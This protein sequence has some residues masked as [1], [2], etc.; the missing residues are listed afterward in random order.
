MKI[1]KLIALF[2][3]VAGVNAYAIDIWVSPSGNDANKGTKDSPLASIMMAQR[4]AREMRRLRK[5]GVENGINI[6]LNDG[7]YQLNE[8]ILLRPE[9]SGCEKSPTVFI[10]ADG[11]NPVISGGV[12]VTG[13]KKLDGELVNLPNEA[14]G[15]VYVT[16]IPS[17]GGRRIEFRQLW[18]DNYKAVRASSMNDGL[19]KRILLADHKNEAL[20]IPKPDFGIEQINQLEL[21]I[22][23]WWAI[24]NLRVKNIEVVGDSAKVTFYQP[25]SRIEFEHPWPAPWID[26]ENNLNGNSAFFFVN[27][28]SLLNTPSEWYADENTGKMYYWPRIGEDLNKADVI[29]PYLETLVE[30]NG[31]FDFPVSNIK[32]E[33]INFQHT[34]WMRPSVKGH[35]PVQAGW[36]ILDA[37]RL[38]E[39]NLDSTSRWENH[40]WI[41][42]QPAAVELSAS[43]NIIFNRCTFKHMAA[44]GLDFITGT[45]HNE[46]KGCLF[47]DIGG[48]GIQ[49]GFFGNASHE[50]HKPYNPT[51]ER[52]VC[53]FETIANN[54]I[55]DVTNEDWGCVGISVGYAHDIKIVHNEVGHLNY[56]GICVGWGWTKEINC[57]K[58]NLVH[59]NYIHHFARMMN[60]IGGVYTLSAQ[61]NS[62]ISE[63]R[64]ESLL[65]APYAHLPEHVQYIYL[66]EGTSYM[67]VENN[68][69]EK[70]IFFE[71]PQVGFGNEWINNNSKVDKLIKEKAGLTA[72]YKDL[73]DAYKEKGL[74]GVVVN[75][76]KQPTIKYDENYH[77][78]EEG[79]GPR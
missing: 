20:W 48:T 64:I 30:F 41:E 2:L 54:L 39:W 40:H 69:V 47:T 60:D 6:I 53:R 51:D 19:L 59:A 14:T 33:R 34:T 73:L 79:R 78:M 75:D 37:Y 29:V 36:S 65:V 21:V 16:D 11:A 70:S 63:N 71:N 61:P 66:D 56:A 38:E 15:N 18:V 74:S 25:E 72:A 55:V 67:R 12:K 77:F 58:N 8:P 7:T 28:L 44:T 4:K 32:F 57:S 42:R 46:V 27:S 62:L 17:I 26:V 76:K 5:E 9:D 1:F 24:A 35:V 13:W 31:S 43:N 49:M 22:H 23:Q 3:I 50:S 68:W 52:E 45:H 10:S